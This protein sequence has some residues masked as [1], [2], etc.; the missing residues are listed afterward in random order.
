MR[1]QKCQIRKKQIKGIFDALIDIQIF[2]KKKKNQKKMSD[3][4]CS[5]MRVTNNEDIL[6]ERTFALE[7]VKKSKKKKKLVAYKNNSASLFSTV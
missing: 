3:N 6:W 5:H 1:A 7:K 2:P 4:D